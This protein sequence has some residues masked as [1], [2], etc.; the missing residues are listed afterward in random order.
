MWLW[1]SYSL[2]LKSRKTEKMVVD[3]RGLRVCRYILLRINENLWRGSPASVLSAYI[4]EELNITLHTINR[5]KKIQTETSHAPTAA[6]NQGL[7][8]HPEDPLLLV[9]WPAALGTGTA[10]PATKAH[11]KTPNLTLQDTYTR[12]S[13]AEI[14]KYHKRH[15]KPNNGLFW[16]LRSGRR[17]CS[18]MVKTRR[19][20]R[21]FLFL[22]PSR[23]STHTL[24]L[25]KTATCMPYAL[26]RVCRPSAMKMLAFS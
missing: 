13:E 11:C 18:H 17:L 5:L 4:T 12:G 26:I 2:T 15:F 7:I 24:H 10:F 8:L 9:S 6:K 22:R 25:D 23:S 1:E 14:P 3:L 20:K 19:L 21:E 16:L